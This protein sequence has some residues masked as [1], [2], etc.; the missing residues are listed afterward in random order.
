[1]YRHGMTVAV[2]EHGPMGGTCLNRG[3][4]PTKM[5]TYPADII[6]TIRDAEK[7][8]ITAR[9]DS[10]DFKGIM[11]HM[12]HHVRSDSQQQGQV[13]DAAPDLDWYKATG[14]FVDNYTLQVGTEII[15][16]PLVFIASGARPYIPPIQGI[17][18]V[19]Y[20]T[21]K[22]ALDL[23][24]PPKSMIIV[25]G[26]YI[27]A[28]Y[29]HFFDAVGTDVTIL[30]RN[31]QFLPQEDPEVSQL[32]LQELRKRFNIQTNYEVL[33]ALQSPEGILVKARN[34]FIGNIEKF[35]GE[36]LLLATGRV[37]NSDLLKPEITGVDIDKRGFIKVNQYLQTSKEG[38]W[39]FGD[40]IGKHMFRHM[41]NVEAE[42]AWY[43]ANA[44]MEPGG[45]H[46]HEHMAHEPQLIPVNYSAVPHAVFTYPPVASVGLTPQQARQQG[47]EILIGKAEY[48]D[49][50][51]GIAMGEPSGFV[52]IVVENQTQRILGAHIVGPFA[53][54][55][56]QEVINVM[57][58]DNAS[59]IPLIQAIHIHP[60]LPE[61]VIRA[62]TR[63]TPL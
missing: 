25:G 60:A 26:G 12:R 38:I 48:T 62:F 17:D 18:E 46:R 61:V 39:A 52:K 6:Q 3:C 32:A 27:A 42:I 20:L 58:C 57:S 11:E 2:V 8:G 53:P 13:V 10:I 37:P 22:T 34:R 50:A 31:P 49:A 36:T 56:I 15:S 40:A 28:E 23:D 5:L 43:N 35:S 24:E 55:L 33:E 44:L 19:D 21:S 54:I 45:G 47:Y 14:E 59:M 63:L 1:A 4:I 7:L 30:G 29:G 16:A 9:I 41:A 51:K